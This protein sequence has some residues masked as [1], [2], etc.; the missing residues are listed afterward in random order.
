MDTG[1]VMKATLQFHGERT[2]FAIDYVGYISYPQ[3]T[4]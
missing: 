1:D 3:G 2:V 4:K